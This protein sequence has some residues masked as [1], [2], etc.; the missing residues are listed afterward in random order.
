MCTAGI[1]TALAQE[2]NILSICC[3]TGEFLLAFQTA[4]I[5]VNLV[6]VSS[7]DC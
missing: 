5:T 1:L 7:T 4:I 6:L 2:D 3:S